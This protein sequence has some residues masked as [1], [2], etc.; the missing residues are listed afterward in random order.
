MRDSASWRTRTLQILGFH[1][2]NCRQGEESW[3]LTR[4]IGSSR[5]PWGYWVFFVLSCCP[6][7]YGDPF[8]DD[9]VG[10]WTRYG[11]LE[12]RCTAWWWLEPW[13]FMTFQKKLGTI[14]PSDELIFFRTNSNRY[15]KHELLMVKSQFNNGNSCFVLFLC[16]F[17]RQPAFRSLESAIAAC[18]KAE[19]LF[20]LPGEYDHWTEICLVTRWKYTPWNF[21]YIMVGVNPPEQVPKRHKYFVLAPPTHPQI[22]RMWKL[23]YA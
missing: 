11:L 13:N 6:T 4:K 5:Q 2:K 19:V 22:A 23:L 14:I 17:H 1:V 8:S 10:V 15:N 18:G 20:W 21:L 9:A 12:T 3:D 7:W 16:C